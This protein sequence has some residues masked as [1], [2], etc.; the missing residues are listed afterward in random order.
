M[1]VLVIGAGPAGLAAAWRLSEAGH[2]VTVLERTDR[3]GGRAAGVEASGARAD[4]LAQFLADT[5]AT[6]L[7][8][9]GRAG[10]TLCPFGGHDALRRRGRVYPLEYGSVARLLAS[11]ALSW[12]LKWKLGTKYVPLLQ[13][14]RELWSNGDPDRLAHTPWDAETVADWGSRELGEEFL[15]VVAAPLLAAYLL[16]IPEET[17]AALFHLLAWRGQRSRPVAPDSGWS[18]AWASVVGGLEARG[19]RVIRGRTVVGLEVGDDQVRVVWDGG[20]DEAEAVVVA[21]PPAVAAPWFEAWAPRVAQWLRGYDALPGLSVWVR[22]AARL[23]AGP[24]AVAA[25]R[26][27]RGPLAALLHLDAKENRTGGLLALLS[28][29]AARDLIDA[30]TDAVWERVRPVV[31]EWEPRA[32]Q[33]VVEVRVFRWPEGSVRYRPGIFAH[34]RA[35]SEIAGDLGPRVRLA[36]DYLV[37]PSIDGAVRSGQEAARA[38]LPLGAR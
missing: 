11:G 4:V 18:A 26:S 5:D 25:P 19:C 15:D 13:R 33:G 38:L 8:W 10:V 34:R 23:R 31:E 9:L 29:E 36:G 30:P 17:T 16:A 7:A 24:F 32:R 12:S 3:I 6:A 2:A 1:R 37:Y 14:N 21:V 22:L 20:G 28:P 27:E 35:W